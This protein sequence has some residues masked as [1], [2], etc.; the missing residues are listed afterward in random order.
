MWPEDPVQLR[1]HYRG[2]F[3]G[4]VLCQALLLS[5]TDKIVNIDTSWSQVCC[6]LQD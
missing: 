5:H 3:N 4:C 2:I 6:V 1:E